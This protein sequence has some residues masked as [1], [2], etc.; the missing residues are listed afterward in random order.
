MYSSRPPGPDTT[1]QDQGLA[2]AE[3]VD[4][5]ALARET[6]RSAEGFAQSVREY[7]EQ[8]PAALDR[9][10]QAMRDFRETAHRLRG[11]IPLDDRAAESR[12]ATRNARGGA[13]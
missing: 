10:H 11:G 2:A 8:M 12:P 3:A 13:R 5:V 6:R 7:S 9:F 4:I 1:R